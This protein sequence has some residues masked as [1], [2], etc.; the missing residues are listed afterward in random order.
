MASRLLLVKNLTEK[1][2]LEKKNFLERAKFRLNRR[3]DTVIT[4]I[5]AD[6]PI[7]IG[8]AR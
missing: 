2:S 6:S 4:V 8:G 5:A 1:G 3:N 7:K